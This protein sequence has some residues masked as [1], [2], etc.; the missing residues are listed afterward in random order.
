[1][2]T[3]PRG[4]VE[5]VTRYSHIDLRGG[6]IDGGVLGKWHVGVNWWISPDW[7]AGISYGDARTTREGMKGTT[8]MLLTRLQWFHAT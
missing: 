2:P 6:T 1:M 5:L 3:S 4:A 7:K 8:R